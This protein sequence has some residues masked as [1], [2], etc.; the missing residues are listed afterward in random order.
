[1]ASEYVLYYGDYDYNFNDDYNWTNLDLDYYYGYSRSDENHNPNAAKEK[2]E[3]ILAKIDDCNY[4]LRED[5][6]T[7]IETRNQTCGIGH[8]DLKAA[9]EYVHAGFQNDWKILNSLTVAIRRSTTPCHTAWQRTAK[10][11]KSH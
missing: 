3:I 4:A 9:M 11:L 2:I 8:T 7:G 10:G 6:N 5:E 1:M